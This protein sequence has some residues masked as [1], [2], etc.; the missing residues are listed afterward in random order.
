MR[1]QDQAAYILHRDYR[2]TSQILELFSRD[3]GR[4][5]VVS[6]GS[7]GAKS[8]SRAVLQPFAPLLVS[9]SGKGE[10]PTLTGSEV[11]SYTPLKLRGNALPSA[12]Y[13]NELLVKLLHKH[14][15]HEEVFFLYKNTLEL[16]QDIESLEKNL[17][18]FEIKLLQILGFGMNLINDAETGEI[19]QSDKCYRYYIEHGPVLATNSEQDARSLLITGSS[20]IAFEKELLDSSQA[21]KE[22]K[23]LMR[24]VLSYYMEGKPIKSREFN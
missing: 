24:Y 1:V 20:L 7:R 8:R 6:K 17:R 22:I 16:L 21:L 23:S 18:V 13:I 11:I 12:F 19:V 9:W 3:H 10:M 4:I 15:M 2:D 14:D 5:T